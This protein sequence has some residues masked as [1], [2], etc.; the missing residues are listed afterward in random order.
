MQKTKQTDLECYHADALWFGERYEELRSLYPDQWVGV[1]NKKVVGA[2]EDAELLMI[3][4]KSK[5]VS[6][7]NM[8][9]DFVSTK[10]EIWAFVSLT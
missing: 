8:F 9:F 10:D 7:D 6:L 4:L 3:E 2:H 1:R 5:G